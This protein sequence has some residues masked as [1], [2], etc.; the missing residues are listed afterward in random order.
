MTA[1]INTVE[2]S[3]ELF[4]HAC[5]I[6]VG[7]FF[8]FYMPKKIRAA[9]ASGKGGLSERAI[10]WYIWAGIGI[11]VSFSWLIVDKLFFHLCER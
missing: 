10:K 6:V 5:L 4:M 8:I 9:V 2:R 3:I 1:P 11:A 7:L